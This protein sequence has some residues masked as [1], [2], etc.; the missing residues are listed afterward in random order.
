VVSRGIFGGGV[1]SVARGRQVR[2]VGGVERHIS[3]IGIRP[4]RGAHRARDGS[5]QYAMQEPFLPRSLR[6]ELHHG[7]NSACFAV[8]LAHLMG[9]DPIFLV[10]F[11]LQNG[12]NYFF[13]NTNPVTRRATLYQ[14]ERALAW[15]RWYEKMFPGRVQLDPSFNGPIY[16]VFKKA[17]FDARQATSGDEPPHDRGHEPVA[18]RE[19]ADRVEGLR[20][21]ATVRVDRRDPEPVRP[22]RPKGRVI[23]GR[24]HNAR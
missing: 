21:P 7:G 17:N 15:L 19:D 11:T 5:M 20:P 14:S 12:G 9:A 16:D 24:P 1:F 23:G 3:E 10:G 22:P 8:Q 4:L 13:A 2:I 6:E 18:H